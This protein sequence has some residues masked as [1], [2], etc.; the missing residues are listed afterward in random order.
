MYSRGC[1]WIHLLLAELGP[2]HLRNEWSVVHRF[3]Q[4]PTVYIRIEELTLRPC[5]L[6]NPH[7]AGSHW[8]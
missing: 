4:V 8:I 2:N 6:S 7:F 3:A 1:M 5:S